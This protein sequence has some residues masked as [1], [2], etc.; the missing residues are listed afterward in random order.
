MRREL[1]GA[2][3]SG[4]A[5]HGG[6]KAESFLLSLPEEEQVVHARDLVSSLTQ[7][8]GRGAAIEAFDSAQASGKPALTAAL[9]RSIA[10][11]FLDTTWRL[12]TP[13]SACAWIAQHAG[14]SYLTDDILAHAAGDYAIKDPVNAISWLTTLAPR[15]SASATQASATG[16]M[17]RWAGGDLTAMGTW[18]TSNQDGPLYDYLASSYAERVAEVDPNAAVEWINTIKQPALRQSAQDKLEAA[19]TREASAK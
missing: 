17:K 4:L 18:L 10:D 15:L 11:E 14:R 19:A 16:I 9:F 1:A 2:L 12:K 8:G 13:E 5:Q 6:G 7:A 3:I